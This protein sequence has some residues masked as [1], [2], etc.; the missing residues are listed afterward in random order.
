MPGSTLTCGETPGS[1]LIRGDMPDS[2]LIRIFISEPGT[3]SASCFTTGEASW[4][5]LIGRSTPVLLH[6]S[7]IIKA[8][9]L[10]SE[11]GCKITWENYIL[12]QN[13]DKLK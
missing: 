8:A 7:E 12:T 11:E 2:V 10:I 5:V 3:S 9:S 13:D 1:A 6:R 4:S